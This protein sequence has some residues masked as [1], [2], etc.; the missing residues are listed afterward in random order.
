MKNRIRIGV[1]IFDDD[2]LLLVK[3]IDPKSGF[4]W[5]VPPGG[6]LQNNETIFECGKREVF[7]ET[8]LKI[9]LDKLVYI[10]QFIYNHQGENTIDV[11]LTSS[12]SFAGKMHITNLKGLGGDEHFIKELKFFSESEIKEI[13]VFPKILKDGMWLDYKA[14]F[15]DLKFIGVEDDSEHTSD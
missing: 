4:T 15:P 2:K 8:N 6:G 1:L 12:S 10:R 9:K 14:N 13:V 7:E 3:H 5:W 11:Y